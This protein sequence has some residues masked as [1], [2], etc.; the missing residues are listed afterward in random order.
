MGET[1]HWSREKCEESPPEEGVAE[2]RCDELATAPFPIPL[3]GWWEKKVE[4]VMSERE[5]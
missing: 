1:P 4:K 5:P 3:H 2:T